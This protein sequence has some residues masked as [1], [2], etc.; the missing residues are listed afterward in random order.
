MR[1]LIA[2]V[3]WLGAIIGAVAVSST[4]ANS[5]HKTGGSAGTHVDPSSVEAGRFGIDVPHR[6]PLA[7][8]Q[9]RPQPRRERRAAHRC[10]AGTKTE[11]VRR[12]Q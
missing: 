2:L 9:Q 10:R 8:D 7:G 4:V 3:I 11:P 1:L 6:Q 12:Q 5:I